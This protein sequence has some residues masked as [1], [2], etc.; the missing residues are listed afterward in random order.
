MSRGFNGFHLVVRKKDGRYFA[1][2][3]SELPLNK[4]FEHIKSFGKW[5]GSQVKY[6]PYQDAHYEA[7]AYARKMNERK[8][9]RKE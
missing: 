3:A 5:F 9:K 1:G 2:A 6:K 7:Y 4:G 8:E